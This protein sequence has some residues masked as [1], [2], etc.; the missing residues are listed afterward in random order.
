MHGIVPPS[1]YWTLGAVALHDTYE[2]GGLFAAL[3]ATTT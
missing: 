3:P 1:E 2:E